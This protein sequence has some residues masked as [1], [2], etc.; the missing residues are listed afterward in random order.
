MKTAPFGITVV[1]GSLPL[2]HLRHPVPETQRTFSTEI[3][4]LDPVV[5]S[6]T[7]TPK[8]RSFGYTYSYTVHEELQ[9][10]LTVVFPTLSLS[11]F[12]SFR[13]ADGIGRDRRRR[14]QNRDT[15]VGN[16]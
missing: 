7:C 16:L 2:I 13:D 14:P 1:V 4:R 3:L 8:R 6:Y 5:T 11:G 9:L 15:R 12:Q 10:I